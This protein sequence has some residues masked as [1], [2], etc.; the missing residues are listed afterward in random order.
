MYL[1][2]IFLLLCTAVF[3]GLCHQALR[4]NEHDGAALGRVGS[5]RRIVVALTRGRLKLGE[6]PLRR[7]SA[8]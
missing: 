1:I 7:R 8:V 5:M 6:A 4:R 3:L 2:A